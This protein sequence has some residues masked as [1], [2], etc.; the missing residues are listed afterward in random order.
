MS[1]IKGFYGFALITK[2]SFKK[3]RGK[4]SVNQP[5]DKGGFRGK[6]WNWKITILFTSSIAAKVSNAK[7]LIAFKYEKKYKKH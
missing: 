5:R 3:F 2:Y 7:K 6:T 1:Q 4:K